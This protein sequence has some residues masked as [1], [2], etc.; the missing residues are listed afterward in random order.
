M[1]SGRPLRGGFRV[2]DNVRDLYTFVRDAAGITKDFTLCSTFP[3]REYNEAKDSELSMKQA[4]APCAAAVCRE[5][6]HR[7][8]GCNVVSAPVRTG[9]VPFASAAP[10]AWP[11]CVLVLTGPCGSRAATVAVQA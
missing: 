9:T 11:E 10:T 3:V 4:G 1:P 5:S 8:R 2:T 6:H 7:L